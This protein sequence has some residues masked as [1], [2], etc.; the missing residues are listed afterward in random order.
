MIATAEKLLLCFL[1]MQV[2]SAVFI[3]LFIFYV[4]KKG[5]KNGRQ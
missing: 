4:V 2:L 5:E 3:L 1:I